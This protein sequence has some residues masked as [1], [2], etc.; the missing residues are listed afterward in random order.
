MEMKG[1]MSKLGL[2]IQIF[3]YFDAAGRQLV[4]QFPRFRRYNNPTRARWYLLMS[5]TRSEREKKEAFPERI[6]ATSH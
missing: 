6:S 3:P 2:L 5:L 1:S 4:V